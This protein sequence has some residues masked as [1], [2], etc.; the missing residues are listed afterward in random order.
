MAKTNSDGTTSMD[1]Q[2]TINHCDIMASKKK[3]K[4]NDDFDKCERSIWSHRTSITSSFSS[5][6]R[7]DPNW[8]ERIFGKKEKEE[9]SSGGKD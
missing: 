2:E 7:R 8:H 1:L 6:T 9:S 3:K 5:I 4:Q